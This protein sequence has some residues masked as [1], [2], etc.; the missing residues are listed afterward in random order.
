MKYM[1]PNL[2]VL[3]VIKIQISFFKHKK[4]LYGPK[5]APRAWYERLSNFILENDFTKGKV[6]T[7]LFCKTFKNDIL[8]VQIYVDDIIFGYANSTC[9]RNSL[10]LCLTPF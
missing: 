1:S 7:T 10:S 5:Q 8:V 9:A 2:L 4:S 3:K 6:D